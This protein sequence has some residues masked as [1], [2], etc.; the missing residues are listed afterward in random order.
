MIVLNDTHIGAIRSA[1]TTPATAVGL[2]KYALSEFESLLDHINEDLT[3]LGDLFDTYSIPMTDLL[4]AYLMLRKWMTKGHNLTLVPG[5]HDLSTDSAKMSSFQFM[6]QLLIDEPTVQYL[7]KGGWVDETLSVYAIP[8]VA[9]QDIFDMELAKVPDCKFLL[10]HC[11]Y[12][13]FFAK[14][15]DHSLNLSEAQAKACKAETIVFAHEHAPRKA[16]GGKVVIMGN[17]FP[18]SVSDCLDG[19]DKF[20]HRITAD[21]VQPIKVWDRNTHYVEM[22]WRSPEPT[23]ANFIRFV[24]TA[25][26]E[27]A[28]AAADTIA[29]Y[30]KA[31][32]AFV[33][34]NGVKVQGAEGQAQLE[35]ESLEQVRAFDVM[36]ALKDYLTEKEYAKLQSLAQQ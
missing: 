1:G 16:L 21:A 15:S 2:R 10:V 32:E 31:S 14:D 36:A 6:S 25:S 24:G 19:N 11:N 34:G 23:T 8:H 33:V 9:N 12:D 26:A 35:V 18:T 7:S 4:S 17:Q 13:N 20:M 29:R 30:R 22:D 27:E 28:A 3:I 5:N